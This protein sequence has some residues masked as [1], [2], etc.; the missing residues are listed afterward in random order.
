MAGRG[1]AAG[2]IWPAY[3]ATHSTEQTLY[4]G[5]D[6]LFRR[7]DY[8]V[9]I[10]GNNAAAHYFSG[11]R[12]VAGIMVATS[13]RIFPR[14]ADGQAVPEPLIVSIDVSDIAFT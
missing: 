3:L 9:E 14:A 7:H 12:L 5:D 10:A 11:Y 4:V 8:N 1:A 2:V 6:G 13:H